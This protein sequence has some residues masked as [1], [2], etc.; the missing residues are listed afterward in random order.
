MTI[1]EFILAII[2]G[3]Y[4]TA[5]LTQPMVKSV[6]VMGYMAEYDLTQRLKMDRADELGIMGK[7]MDG[8]AEKLSG[9]VAQIRGSAE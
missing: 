2:A 3:V 5:S 6:D 4:L 1:I 9:V 7:A 8:F